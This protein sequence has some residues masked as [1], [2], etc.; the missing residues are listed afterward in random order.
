[1]FNCAIQVQTKNSVGEQIEN[2]CAFFNLKQ[3]ETVKKLFHPMPEFTWIPTQV[4]PFD[5]SFISATSCADITSKK[6]LIEFKIIFCLPQLRQNNP[7][8]L[9]STLKTVSTLFFF[10][11]S[12]SVKT[13]FNC[14]KTKC[15]FRQQK[16]FV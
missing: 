12:W 5:A 1:M 7:N 15:H 3:L 4:P 2:K 10:N 13:V 9:H 14:T 6:F 8:Q 16:W 11:C